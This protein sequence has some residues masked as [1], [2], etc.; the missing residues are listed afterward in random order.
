MGE[1]SSGKTAGSFLIVDTFFDGSG[2][3]GDGRKRN[4]MKEE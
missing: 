3:G 2:G 1:S 4:E